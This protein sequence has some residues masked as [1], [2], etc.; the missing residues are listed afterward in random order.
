M[1]VSWP[2]MASPKP[3]Y[4]PKIPFPNAIILGGW[5]FPCEFGDDASIQSI[6]P[7]S[8]NGIPTALRKLAIAVPKTDLEDL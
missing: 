5:V 3:N 7:S 6:M 8:T 1:K 2:F 4:L